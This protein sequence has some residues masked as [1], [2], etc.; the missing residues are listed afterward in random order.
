MSLGPFLSD[1]EPED[2]GEDVGPSDE[3]FDPFADPVPSERAVAPETR[4]E[5]KVEIP[6]GAR[7]VHV[8]EIERFLE[9]GYRHAMYAGQTWREDYDVPRARGTGVHK[10]REVAF[11]AYLKTGQLPA[12]EDL[13]DAAAAAVSEAM[14]GAEEV[15]GDEGAAMVDA[16]TDEAVVFVRADHALLLP[17][18]A[19]HVIEVEPR[20][21]AE[22]GGEGIEP[23]SWFLSGSP[24]SVGRDPTTGKLVLPDLKTGVKATSQAA[25]NTSSQLTGYAFLA[26][27]RYGEIPVLA[28]HSLRILK[29]LPKAKPGLFWKEVKGAKGEALVGV[30]ERK[31]TERTD[32]DLGSFLRRLNA[33]VSS[34]RAGIALPATSSNFMSPCHRC[35]HRGHAVASQ[36]CPFA[37]AYRG[38]EGE[39]VD[40][41]SL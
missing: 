14:K 24:D 32:A 5:E 30:V 12:L 16:A 17:L 11:R 2:F 25:L 7:T 13:E 18:L 33:F 19:P 28:H 29:R 15:G 38:G 9:C 34:Q 40:D 36:R 10:A 37:P 31:H 4:E 1:Q 41:G 22:I 21:V 20:F 35:A 26:A 8:T 27:E 23:R 3:T 39:E 6:P